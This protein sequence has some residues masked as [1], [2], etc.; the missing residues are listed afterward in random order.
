MPTGGTTRG[1][2]FVAGHRASA[3]SPRMAAVLAYADESIL[4]VNL[5]VA[6][7]DFVNRIATGLGV[8]VTD[9]ELQGYTY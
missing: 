1:S 6:Y 2:C 9:E 8:D 3:P 5:I 4:A 7:F